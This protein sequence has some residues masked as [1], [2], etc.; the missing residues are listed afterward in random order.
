MSP[1]L[2]MVSS[3][4]PLFDQ[5][6]AAERSNIL[7]AQCSL[8]ITANANGRCDMHLTAVAKQSKMA[9]RKG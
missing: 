1:K 6:K 9:S 8:A 4:F 2:V 3:T 7:R 5:I